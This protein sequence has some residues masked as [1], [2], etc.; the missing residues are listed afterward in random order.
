MPNPLRYAH[1]PEP[2]LSEIFLDIIW[3][4]PYLR[5]ALTRAQELALPNWRSVSGALYNVIWNHLTNRDAQY[6][7]KDI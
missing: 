7:V 4:S 3:Q 5:D 2:E 1:L 6:G